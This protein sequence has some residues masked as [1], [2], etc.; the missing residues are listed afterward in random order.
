MLILRTAASMSPSPTGLRDGRVARRWSGRI[1]RPQR[2]VGTSHARK[3]HHDDIRWFGEEGG[4]GWRPEFEGVR[5]PSELPRFI[6]PLL[7]TFSSCREPDH[8][9][10][11]TDACPL[12]FQAD[13]PSA[14]EGRS[15]T[16]Y[17]G[18]LAAVTRWDVVRACAVESGAALAGLFGGGLRWA[19]RCRDL[20]DWHEARNAV[21]TRSPVMWT[22]L[23]LSQ[24]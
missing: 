20:R 23:E 12:P 22:T 14:L 4:P 5:L 16:R 18:G 21:P 9:A 7:W 15:T 3:K 19:V 2:V 10:P 24:Y 11:H 8:A 6:L 17:V 1:T 13:P